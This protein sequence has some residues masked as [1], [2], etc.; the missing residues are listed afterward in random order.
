MSLAAMLWALNDAP[1]SN[2]T[3]AFV[4]VALA[5]NAWDDGR[6]AFPSVA[7]IAYR[8]RV[9]ERT[10][11]RTLR[12]LEAAGV[13]SR[14]EDQSPAAVYGRYA[15]IVYELDMTRRRDDPPPSKSKRAAQQGRQ[16]VTPARNEGRQSVTPHPTR[17]DTDDTQGVTLVSPE[18]S[19]NPPVVTQGVETHRSA[20]ASANPPEVPTSAAGPLP[21]AGAAGRATERD[22]FGPLYPTCP[23]HRLSLDA[24]ACR[25]CGDQREAF[26][27]AEL[28][29]RSQRDREASRQQLDELFAHR[30]DAIPAQVGAERARSAIRKS[31]A[32][33]ATRRPSQPGAAPAAA[34]TGGTE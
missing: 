9:S 6:G 24:P 21:A 2:P 14:A 30:R 11:Q 32:N 31:G 10:V 3:E 20:H 26:E 17:G 28:H 4:L 23:A 33:G 18:P 12:D 22:Q 34:T 15:P 1:V 19:T 5:D 8:T 25:R 29:R 16:S 13:I 27:A 7:T